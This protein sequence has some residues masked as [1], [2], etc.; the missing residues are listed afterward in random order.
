MHQFTQFLSALSVPSLAL[1]N[2]TPDPVVQR[3]ALL[4]L[5]EHPKIVPLAGLLHEGEDREEEGSAPVR[6][7]QDNRNSHQG[8]YE[9]RPAETE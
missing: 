5:L 4:C 3:L 9:R 2:A 7:E 1:G 8:G 6:I